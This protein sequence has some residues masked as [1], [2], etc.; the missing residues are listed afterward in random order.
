MPIKYYPKEK[1]WKIVSPT[2]EEQTAL[3]EIGKLM[4]IKGMAGAFT[5]EMFQEHLQGVTI[6]ECWRA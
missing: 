4:V 3:Y 1:A 5:N 2:P 6:D